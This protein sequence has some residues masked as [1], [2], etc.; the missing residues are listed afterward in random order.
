MLPA[1][2]SSFDRPVSTQPNARHATVALALEGI[3]RQANSQELTL[4]ISL[5]VASSPGRIVLWRGRHW[6][7][8]NVNHVGA[9]NITRLTLSPLVTDAFAGS[10]VVQAIDLAKPPSPTIE[11]VEDKGL[12]NRTGSTLTFRWYPSQSNSPAQLYVLTPGDN[13]PIDPRI[14]PTG[15]LLHDTHR[16]FVAPLPANTDMFLRL[17]SWN[18]YLRSDPLTLEG[19]TDDGKLEPPGFTTALSMQDMAESQQDNSP[20][21][22]AAA[23][24]LDSQRSLLEAE[25]ATGTKFTDDE[26]TVV[27]GV[28]DARLLQDG[29]SI[30]S[31]T[32]AP[33]HGVRFGQSAI[34]VIAVGSG[35]VGSQTV[36]CT[37]FCTSWVQF[38]RAFAFDAAI[39]ADIP[40][41]GG[42]ILGSPSRILTFSPTL[43]RVI[44]AITF[45]NSVFY[46]SL[47]FLGGL[48]RLVNVIGRVNPTVTVISTFSFP[49]TFWLERVL[50]DTKGIL[51]SWQSEGN[52]Y[53]ISDLHLQVRHGYSVNGGAQPSVL[54]GF[55]GKAYN[56]RSR[57][58]RALSVWDATLIDWEST[59]EGSAADTPG[60]SEGWRD[61][62]IP[63]DSSG[64][65]R[66]TVLPPPSPGGGRQTSPTFYNFVH[67]PGQGLTTKAKR[68]GEL[69][70]HF[71]LKGDPM[72]APDDRVI[73]QFRLRI[74][75]TTPGGEV[76]EPSGWTAGKPIRMRD[77]AYPD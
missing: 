19:V 21:S 2:S 10:I 27:L 66:F 31:A 43:T 9:D 57:E 15:I 25:P 11:P 29:Y 64:D 75:V 14:E 12:E 69:T 71:W 51:L 47:R 72:Q 60:W 32:G 1:L 70:Q 28:W 52:G 59:T 24:R 41:S 17:W 45:H 53:P 44:S 77:F 74:L 73:L 18:G 7:V 61:V 6:V 36:L 50:T 8:R 58:M 35:S 4:D 63:T 39:L 5:D 23:D 26:F 76:L 42:G 46:S 48:G 67:Q 22:N 30:D 16:A 20:G 54:G 34:V 65:G 13:Q 56:A 37:T 62:T 3:R 68:L 38:L 55:S 49:A 40:I 33:I